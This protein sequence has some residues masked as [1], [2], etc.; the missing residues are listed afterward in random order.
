MER[1]IRKQGD[2]DVLRLGLATQTRSQDNLSCFGHLGYQV[3][4]FCYPVNWHDCADSQPLP[5]LT[6]ILRLGS[7]DAV[8]TRLP[9]GLPHSLFILMVIS[10]SLHIKNASS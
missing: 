9:H 2:K 5:F 10:S 3:F 4:A 6:H 1:C 7:A 8:H